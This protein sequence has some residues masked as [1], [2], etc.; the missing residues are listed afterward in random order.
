MPREELIEVT[1]G[2]V[3]RDYRVFYQDDSP[4]RAEAVQFFQQHAEC[5]FPT[6]ALPDEVDGMPIEEANAYLRRHPFQEQWSLLRIGRKNVICDDDLARLRHLPEL[7]HVQISS[8]RITDAGV[9]HLVHLPALTRLGIYSAGVTD[10]CLRAIRTLRSLRSLDLQA[11]PNLSRASVLAAV[12]AMPWLQD[13]WPP[14][15]PV[16][17]AMCRQRSERSRESDANPA[18]VCGPVE[19]SGSGHPL[20]F[21]DLSRRPMVRP[22]A[23]LF[24]TDDIWRLD[25]I[26]CGVEALPD[27]I[28]NL[29]RLRT[30]YANWCR[31]RE[32]PDT[33]GRL[34][35][36]E[37]LWLNNNQLTRLP[38]ALG[39]LVRL[40]QLCLDT[41]Q[42]GRFP[43][44]LLRLRCLEELRLAGNGIAVLPEELGNLTELRS[45]SLGSNNL[46]TV[47]RSIAK[48][49]KL[50]Y[51]GLQWNPLR[52][53]PDELWQ[54]P[55]L[56]TLNL[57]NTGFTDLP[58]E[59]ANIP[60]IIGLPGQRV[61]S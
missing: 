2:D 6:M 22:P 31:L 61:H 46:A 53:L 19:P 55:C 47:P 54:L 41:N 50:T 32:L 24:T 34:T 40:K 48:L 33:L 58:P 18:H 7:D 11:S 59:A 52:S 15:D 12:D 21:V 10:A 17:L 56:I 20:R 29:T 38:D 36:L 60:N 23:D 44:A 14:P 37:D 4:E 3:R 8:D 16:R 51:L 5:L 9:E 42:L 35:A 1:S 45:L 13:V 25:M 39:D 28:G 57:G 26:H 30:L 49:E 43:G 27:E